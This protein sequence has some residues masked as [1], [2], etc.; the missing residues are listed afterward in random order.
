MNYRY[1]IDSAIAMC[2]E[3]RSKA[4]PFLMIA[5][6]F[7]GA[8]LFHSNAES[9]VFPP[10]LHSYGIRKAGP[11]HL[12][13]LMGTR[14]FFDDPQGLATTRLKS[15]DKPET[16]KDDD[17]VI[18]YGVN[19]GRHQILFNISMYALDIYGKMGSDTGCFLYPRGVA[20]NEDGDIYIADSGNNRLVRLFNP[21]ATIIWKGIL[22]GD[23]DQGIFLNGPS[24]VALDE[25]KNVYA[26]DPGNKRIVVFDND[27]KVKTV[28]GST[29]IGGIVFENGPTALAVADGAARW[30][31]FRKEKF[32]FCADRN[33]SR[34][35][36]LTTTGTLEKEVNLPDGY[37]AN[38][39]AIDYYHNYWI[40]DSRKHCVL[41]FDHN[42]TLLDIFGSY[43]KGDNQFDQPRGITIYK[44]Y[45]QTFIAERKGAQYFWVGTEMK[46]VSCSS[47]DNGVYT[48]AVDATEYSFISYFIINDKDTSY[49]AKR[50]MVFPGKQ[51]VTLHSNIDV[52]NKTGIFKIE[53]TYSSYTYNS[54]TYP[55]KVNVN[56]QK[57]NK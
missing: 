44:R 40:T 31:F 12:F 48:I 32:I 39:G 38:Y 57:N 5:L 43:G 1:I 9:L 54:W 36:R 15:W 16:E 34:V 33:G 21:K 13:M 27:G 55:L 11:Q 50:Y 20:A 35:R 3:R 26:T 47:N 51:T 25:A 49:L 56:N 22:T 42:L 17:E 14:T 4:I 41:K 8:A 23:K 19:A 2:I 18:V 7:S 24:R 29:G 6:L 28:I 30:S 10:Y 46:S 53:P 37:C 45:G 52:K